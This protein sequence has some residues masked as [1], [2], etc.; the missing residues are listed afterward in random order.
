MT[1][2]EWALEDERTGHFVAFYD[3]ELAALRA[4]A[5]LGDRSLR[6]VR[7]PPEPDDV[8]CSVCGHDYLSSN[9]PCSRMDCPTASPP[10]ELDQ[11]PDTVPDG[12]VSAKDPADGYVMSEDLARETAFEAW[13]NRE[14]GK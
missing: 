10:V 13:Y 7:T 1:T 3:D 12:W 4:K 5:W 14:K 8:V 2:H 6:V 11:D 9:D